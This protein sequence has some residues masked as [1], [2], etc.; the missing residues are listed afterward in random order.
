MP[1]KLG[2]ILFLF[3]P[4]KP[5]PSGESDDPETLKSAIK[6]CKITTG[7][8]PEPMESVSLSRREPIFGVH[9]L[10]VSVGQIHKGKCS[11]LQQGASTD[12]LAA[13][14]PRHDKK[15][16]CCTRVPRVQAR[17][18]ARGLW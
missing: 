17:R 5:P 13:L 18:V 11:A 12:R 7:G 9:A 2:F 6:N 8:M 10:V 14:W 4:H 15:I 3:F 16:A 1:H